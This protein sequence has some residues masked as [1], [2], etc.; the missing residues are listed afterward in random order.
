MLAVLMDAKTGP[1]SDCK[2]DE[3]RKYAAT[4]TLPYKPAPAGYWGKDVAA[5]A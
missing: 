1:L 3:H 4:S 2:P 5:S